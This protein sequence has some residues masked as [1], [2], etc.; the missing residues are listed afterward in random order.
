MRTTQYGSVVG[1]FLM[2]SLRLPRCATQN[3][4][5][6]LLL[7]IQLPALLTDAVPSRSARSSLVDPGHGRPP[8]S[9]EKWDPPQSPQIGVHSPRVSSCKQDRK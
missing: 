5:R 8:E 6:R 4:T 7:L 9:T 1:A 3:G 2:H